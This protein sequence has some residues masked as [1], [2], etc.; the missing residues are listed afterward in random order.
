MEQAPEDDQ[1]I[2]QFCSLKY[3]TRFRRMKKADVNG[4]NELPLYTYLKA[5]QKFKGFGNRLK[6]TAM[7]LLLRKPNNSSIP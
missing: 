1:G 7:S 3:K 2:Q 6:A 4:E 5:Q